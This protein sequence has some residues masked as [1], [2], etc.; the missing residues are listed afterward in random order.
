MASSKQQDLYLLGYRH[1]NV[2]EERRLNHQHEAIKHAILGGA[3]IHPSIPVQNFQNAI[4]DLA[5][6]TGVW[7]D[8]V[9]NTYFGG[10]HTAMKG[11]H[12][13]IGFDINT[14]AFNSNPAPG[15]Q[16][17]GHDCTKPFEG[18]YHDTFDLVNIR[19]LAYA[20]SE[21]SFSHV[22]DNAVQL[23]SKAIPPMTPR[24]RR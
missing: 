6:G 15:V 16:L 12:L 24:Q 13:L 17:V 22:I 18:K 21:E 2:E 10:E 9:A 14:H 7:L 19:G 5:C 1:D 23:L 20:L 11:S 4:T 8:D 3:L